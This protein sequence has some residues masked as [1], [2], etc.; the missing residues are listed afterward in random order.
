[1][2][3]CFRDRDHGDS[4]LPSQSARRL[5]AQAHSRQGNGFGCVQHRDHPTTDPVR[6]PAFYSGPA[7][8]LAAR[9]TKLGRS[10]QRVMQMN[11]PLNLVI[12]SGMI[13]L[14]SRGFGAPV[15]SVAFFASMFVAAA[16]V[17]LALASAR[18]LRD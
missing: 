3:F 18:N 2:S 12:G 17:M 6:N 7:L 16:G 4:I 13:W 9:R 5:R 14:G 1:M 10:N 15:L 11:D 8:R